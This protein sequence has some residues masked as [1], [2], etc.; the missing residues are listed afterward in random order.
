[1]AHLAPHKLS[2][3]RNIG[4]LLL[5]NRTY[6][7][8]PGQL[9]CA[10]LSAVYSMNHS[11]ENKSRL[12][13]NRFL[14]QSTTTR[15]KIMCNLPPKRTRNIY[16][17]PN[18]LT[19]SRIII[20]PAIGYFICAGMY[21]QALACFMFAAAT[22]FLDG[23]AARRLKQESDFGAA[24]D[25]VADKLLM[26]VSIISL[27]NVDDIPLFVVKLIVGR[28]LVILGF[29]S[30]IRYLGLGE[31]RSLRKFIDF[32][33]YPTIGFEPTNLSKFNTLLQCLVV[34]ANLAKEPLTEVLPNFS[35]SLTALYV[36]TCATTTGSIAQYASRYVQ[37][38]YYTE[39]RKSKG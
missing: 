19:F 30:A 21:N 1:M 36:L 13:F 22:D 24:L 20:S 5:G 35:T 32:K 12:M 34:V 23:F 9:R 8:V 37:D 11:E 18:A 38:A 39:E 29:A 6:N 10:A 15:H 14:S 33:N 17:I 28:D 26:T 7:K 2:A 3:F 16:T 4:F 31:N 25:P 27:Y